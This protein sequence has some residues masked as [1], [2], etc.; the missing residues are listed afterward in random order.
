MNRWTLFVAGTVLAVPPIAVLDS[1]AFHGTTG[2]FWHYLVLSY[3]E[4]LC[5][6]IGYAIGRSVKP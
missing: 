4:A 6:A 3:A 1:L 5:L 2:F